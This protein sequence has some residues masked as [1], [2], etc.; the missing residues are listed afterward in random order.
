M[1]LLLLVGVLAF[2]RRRVEWGAGWVWPVPTLQ[3][4]DGVMYPAVISDGVGSPRGAGV[5][6]GVDIMYKRRSQADRPE[7]RAHGTRMFFAPTGMVPILAAHDGTIWSAGQTPRGWTVVLDHGKPFA[8]YYTHMTALA[9]AP[10]ARGKNTVTGE[11]TQVRAG[12]VIGLMG[13]D[14]MDKSQT[15]HLHFSVAH[16]GPPEQ[17]AV[18][19]ADAMATWPRSATVFTL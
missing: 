4:K 13:F 6:R 9:V 18:D 7:F 14:P 2:L 10:H 8:S 17:N 11:P 15:T 1:F 19:P 3:T 16:D 5:H 12:D